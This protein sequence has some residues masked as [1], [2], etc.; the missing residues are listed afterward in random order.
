MF[1]TSQKIA[2]ALIVLVSAFFTI[3][4]LAAAWFGF[5]VHKESRFTPPQLAFWMEHA[6]SQGTQKD[7]SLL[8]A[9]LQ[10]VNASV[11]YFHVG[12]LDPEGKLANNLNIFKPGMDALDTENYAWI[13]QVRSEIN[14]EDPQVRQG[15]VDSSAWLMTQGFD[16]IHVDIEPVRPD[17]EAFFLLLEEMRAALPTAKLSV[18]MDEW[19]P[20]GISQIV[21]FIFERK[22]ESYWHSEQIKRVAALVDQM[23]V[24]TYDTTFHDPALYSWW[25]EQQTI[26]LSKTLPQGKELYIGIPAYEDGVDPGAENIITGLEG[27]TRG[28]TNLR[29][30][31]G[32]I[33]GVAVYPYWEIDD[34]EWNTLETL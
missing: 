28:L 33:T 30:K 1:V 17:D 22:I 18:A 3:F 24:M 13:G 12:P 10:K 26:A 11:L 4:F 15:I 9:Q 20:H 19:Q 31:T 14:L 16:G 32:K 6:W 27:Y 23:V 29:S 8:H 2:R 5:G 25:V 21:A 34:D 7:F